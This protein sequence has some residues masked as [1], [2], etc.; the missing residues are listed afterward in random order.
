MTAIKLSRPASTWLAC[1][2]LGWLAPL[3]HAKLE[4]V[5]TTP[6]L[7]ALAQAI[8]GK[9]INLTTLTKPSEDPHFVDA[10][11]SFI[12]KLNHADAL[13]EGG[14]Q[15]EIGWLPTLLQGARNAKLAAGAPGRIACA[16]GVPL[17]EVPATLD[18]SQGDIHALGNP[19]FMSDPANAKIAAQHIAD[20]FCQ[21]DP[22]SCAAYRGNLA[23]F[24]QQLEKKLMD[25]RKLLGPYR[26]RRLVAYHNTWPY[27]AK[28]FEL[29][30]DV[31]LEPK[32]GIPPTPAH[33][34]EV[35]ARM[36][37][38]HIHVIIVEPFQNRKTAETVAADTGAVVADLTQYP[39]GVKGSEGGYLQLMDYL[40]QTLAKALATASK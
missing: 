20:A 31:F 10:K 22:K 9:Q 2:A 25:W 1:L 13:I 19:H 15:L 6:D 40:V 30:I 5:A 3:A 29:N 28:H 32:P 24:S 39:G 35:M 8:G 26:G 34:A 11:P 12:V 14:V 37:D 17:L 27:F 16:Q 21:L 23:E 18:R 4:V 7:A 38:E 36:K 33:L